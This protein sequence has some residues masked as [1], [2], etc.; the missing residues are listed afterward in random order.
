MS[1]GSG[2]RSLCMRLVIVFSVARFHLWIVLA[3]V[4][5]VQQCKGSSV[6]TRILYFVPLK[7]TASGLLSAVTRGVNLCGLAVGPMDRKSGHDLGF[8][9]SQSWVMNLAVMANLSW[10]VSTMHMRV[11]P[12]LVVEP[13]LTSKSWPILYID[14]DWLATF[15]K[16][17]KTRV[18]DFSWSMSAEFLLV[19]VPRA[20]C[21]SVYGDVIC[22]CWRSI[23]MLS[24]DLKFEV[25]FELTSK[26]QTVIALSQLD[27]R[28]FKDLV[29][30]VTWSHG[31]VL[32]KKGEDEPLAESPH[33]S[34][35]G[36][37]MDILLDPGIYFVYVST[38][39][40]VPIT[41]F[42]YHTNYK[43]ASSSETI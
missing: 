27:K 21:P 34:R 8:F 42:S 23:A 10:N 2:Q 25:T 12:L 3:A 14:S 16:I 17:D 33:V 31:F 39:Y 15:S 1:I 40:I 7:S 29:G 22:R 43:I 4:L 6:I 20:P 18:F 37:S 19:K 36:V 11:V 35:R 5:Q 32:V 28:F 30:N 9:D 26:S 13:M 24:T 38:A 41:I